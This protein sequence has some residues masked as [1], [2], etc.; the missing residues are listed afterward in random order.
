MSIKHASHKASRKKKSRTYKLHIRA[1]KTETM[2]S[3]NKPHGA[4]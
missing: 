3:R 2:S 4:L 1:A